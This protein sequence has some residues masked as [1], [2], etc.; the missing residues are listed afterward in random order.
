MPSRHITLLQV[1]VAIE[2]QPMRIGEGLHQF[3]DNRIEDN[4]ARLFKKA[5]PNC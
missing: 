3:K 1:G 2:H 5:A 4:E